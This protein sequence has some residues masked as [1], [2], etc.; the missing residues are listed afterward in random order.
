MELTGG[1]NT[2]K[3]RN[4]FDDLTK[5]ESRTH[6]EN[7]LYD[8]VNASNGGVGNVGK[9]LV[10]NAKKEL[11][12][13][14]VTGFKMDYIQSRKGRATIYGTNTKTKKKEKYSVSNKKLIDW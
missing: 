5:P 14:G 11:K 6:A 2:S 1:G 12:R 8:S 10:S 13:R 7:W 4:A 3:P 9:R